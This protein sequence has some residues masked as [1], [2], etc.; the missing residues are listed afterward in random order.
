MA[1]GERPGNRRVMPEDGAIFAALDI[2]CSNLACLIARA[3]SRQPGGF[4]IVAGG[5]QQSRGFS[6]GSMTDMDGLERCVRL[7]VEDAERQAGARIDQVSLAVTGPRVTSRLLSARHEQKGR[8]IAP[9]DIR[10]SLSSALSGAITDDRAVLS[11]WPVGF[12]V[13]GEGSVRDPTGMVAD[14]FDVHVNLVTAPRTL[15][16]NLTEC[17][18]RAHLRVER[19]VPSCVASGLATLIDDELDN[20]AIC[21]DMGAGVSALAAFLNGGPAWTDL[22]PAGGGLVTADLAQG[23]GTTFAA[24]ERLKVVHGHADRAAKGQGFGESVDCPILGDDGRLHVAR[25]AR[26]RL[27]EFIAPRV[28]ETF[29]LIAERITASSLPRAMPRRAVLTGGAS[30]MDGV[31]DVAAR[32]LNMPVRLARPNAAAYLGEDLDIP[33]FSTAAGLLLSDRLGS[34]DVAWAGAARMNTG[35][36]ASDSVVNRTWHWLKENF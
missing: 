20:G 4:A 1:G 19:M 2:G 18:S 12:R 35:E 29:E 5:R 13:D 25:L 32:I 9:R 36:H 14:A 3:D 7:A 30:Q 33:G 15:V 31:R 11:A 27:A 23:L 24:A 8:E 34:S 17:V 6:G 21:I 10:R 22:V 28:E 26:A 16:R